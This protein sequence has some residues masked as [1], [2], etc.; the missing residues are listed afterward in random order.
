MA[1]EEETALFTP[2]CH[3]RHGQNSLPGTCWHPWEGLGSLSSD[4]RALFQKPHCA[5]ANESSSICPHLHHYWQK[6]LLDRGQALIDILGFWCS[7]N[8]AILHV[9]HGSLAGDDES[10]NQ[11]PAES[12]HMI[13]EVCKLGSEWQNANHGPDVCYI[14]LMALISA[15]ATV[16][17]F[18]NYVLR[19]KGS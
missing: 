6:S 4:L 19:R 5:S 2:G 18:P 12:Y 3:S 17:H 15:N 1:G 10:G 13:L 7:C 8:F 16:Q 14:K 11:A 9:L